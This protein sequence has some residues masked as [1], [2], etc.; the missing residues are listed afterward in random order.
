MTIPP[1][2]IARSKVQ[3]LSSPEFR[4]MSDLEIRFVTTWGKCRGPALEKQVQFHPT[5][6]W[7][8]D[9]AHRESGTAFE[10]EGGAWT[11]GR[12]T[13]PSGFIGDAEKYVE[14]QLLGWKVY[15]LPGVMITDAWLTRLI[16]SL[17]EK[18][19]SA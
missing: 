4:G 13:R 15:R 9:F 17:N 18:R 8:F 16:E 3:G 14:A 2:I 11:K 1:H 5:R 10:V 6:K 12:H 19:K 7:K